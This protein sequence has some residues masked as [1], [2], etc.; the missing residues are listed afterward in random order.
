MAFLGLTA[1]VPALG[2]LWNGNSANW[3]LELTPRLDK[4]RKSHF[5]E[6]VQ[7]SPLKD[8]S[9]LYLKAGFLPQKLEEE[10]RFS[11][12]PKSIKSGFNARGKGNEWIL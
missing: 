2:C 1:A 12:S 7:D 3:V 11:C 9:H 6:L 5:T 4:G 8:F 10:F